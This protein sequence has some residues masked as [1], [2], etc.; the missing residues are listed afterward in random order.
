MKTFSFH[1]IRTA[2][3]VTT[4]GTLFAV[5]YLVN[6]SFFKTS[7]VQ[8]GASQN[9][10]GWTWSETVGWM[11][12]NSYGCDSDKN[13]FVDTGICGGDNSTTIARDYGVSVSTAN[14]ATGGTNNFSGYA[15]SDNIGAVSFTQSDMA[16][17]PSGSCVAQIDWSTG[18]VTG[19]ARACAGTIGG[20]CTGGS[21]TD[22]W[23]GWIKLGGDGLSWNGSVC[24][25]VSDNINTNRCNYGVK[26]TANK[27]GGYAWG[28]DVVGWVD[29]APKIGGISVGPVIGVPPCV[30]ADVPASS[31]GACQQIG[32]CP[33]DAGSTSGIRVGACPTGGTVTQSCTTST[34]L[35]CAPAAGGA[36]APGCSGGVTN[37]ICDAGENP[38]N[39][40]R[41]CKV[42]IKQF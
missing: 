6:P 22:G 20:D 26:I 13:G 10:S 8:A 37:G 1:Q 25:G 7:N 11:S 2:I 14:K 33:A 39:C 23:D 41:D 35:V 28:S 5:A 16:G 12:F 36:V 19:W 24:T 27:F 4:I 30:A 42:K 32:S 31:W 3:A 38:V 18:K 15:W 9:V 17:C 40:P 34:A 29:F 21:R